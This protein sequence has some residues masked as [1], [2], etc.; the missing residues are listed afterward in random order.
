MR[1]YQGWL[2]EAHVDSYQTAR[3][4][5]SFGVKKGRLSPQR[6]SSRGPAD[7]KMQELQGN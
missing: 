3:M 6:I 5:N 1:S 2:N 4:V 7:G